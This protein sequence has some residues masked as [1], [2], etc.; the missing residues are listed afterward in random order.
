HAGVRIRERL[1]RAVRVEET[2]RDSRDPV[3]IA[4]DEARALLVELRQRIDRREPRPLALRRRH[5][6]EPGVLPLP[7]RELL[8]R[9]FGRLDLAT[10][11]VA[12]HPFAVDAHARRD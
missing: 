3:R 8:A 9:A 7:P 12:V 10:L 4:R 1:P 6:L 11:V 5:R 2:Q